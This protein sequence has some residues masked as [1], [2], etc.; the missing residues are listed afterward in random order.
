M[1]A[2]KLALASLPWYKRLIYGRKRVPLDSVGI[3]ADRTAFLEDLVRQYPEPIPVREYER[4]GREQGEAAA[5]L[6]ASL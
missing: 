3:R 6:A 1:D 5:K 2:E 4:L